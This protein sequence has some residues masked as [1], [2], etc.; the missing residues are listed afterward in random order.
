MTQPAVASRMPYVEYDDVAAV[1][2]D[3]GMTFLSVEALE[4]HQAQVHPSGHGDAVPEPARPGSLRCESCQRLFSSA[5]AFQDHNRI[6]HR[7]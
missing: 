6:V 1:C 4:A 5:S 3:C 2:S 7:R